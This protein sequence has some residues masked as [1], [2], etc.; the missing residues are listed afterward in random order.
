MKLPQKSNQQ[1]IFAFYFAFYPTAQNYQADKGD[2]ADGS[3][4]TTRRNEGD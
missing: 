4:E 3:D 2:Q 1:I